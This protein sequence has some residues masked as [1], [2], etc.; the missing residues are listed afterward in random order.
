MNDFTFMYP[1][2]MINYL[3]AN[4]WHFSKGASDFA[5]SLMKKKKAGTKDEQEPIKPYTKEEVDE[6]L[7][8]YGVTLENNQLYDYVYIA[9]KAKADYLGSSIED[10]KHL[11]LHIKD[12]IDDVDRK[13]G[14]IMKMW[15]TMVRGNGVAVPWLDLLD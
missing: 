7:K 11:A 6:L 5:A 14:V 10:E 2:A 15:H 12:E 4:G 8:K 13:E 9:N 3:I 1:P